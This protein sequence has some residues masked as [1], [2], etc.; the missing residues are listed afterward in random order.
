ML[1]STLSWPSQPPPPGGEGGAAAPPP[2]HDTDVNRQHVTLYGISVY[3]RAI[4]RVPF[5]VKSI[6]L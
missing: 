6:H 2:R 1:H 4:W 3:I 5:S